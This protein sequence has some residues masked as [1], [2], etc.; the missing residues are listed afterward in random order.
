MWGTSYNIIYEAREDLGEKILETLKMIDTSLSV[1]NPNSLISR[2]NRNETLQ[3]DSHFQYLFETAKLISGLSNGVYDPTT[4]PLTDLW[5][6]QAYNDTVPSTLQLQNAKL[7][8]GINEC[9]IIDGEIQ[10]K[11]EKTQFDF[12]S[13]AKGYGVDCIA[14]MFK[15][16]DVRNYMIEIG[17]EC[18]AKGINPYK[19]IWK[20]RLDIPKNFE[21]VEISDTYYDVFNVAVATAGNY[22]SLYTSSQGSIG[23]IINPVSCKPVKTNLISATVFAENCVTADA[24]S[25][26][27]F[28]M[29]LKSLSLFIDK[30]PS[31]RI[32]FVQKESNNGNFRIIDSLNGYDK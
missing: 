7:L 31:V 27:C 10:K 14:S 22:R 6:Q 5:T 9:S 4:K 21:T 3:V 28:I 19:H 26:A 17:G 1:F 29:G 2:I 15:K 20:V 12:S 18:M 23:H 11:S 24:L 32:V 13:L 30:F 16:N 8:I 25:T